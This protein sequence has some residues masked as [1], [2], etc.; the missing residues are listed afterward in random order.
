M[1]QIQHLI[2]DLE[3]S[4]PATREAAAHTL[5][6]LGDD[7]RL[8]LPALFSAILR[9]PDACPW[10]GTALARLGHLAPDIDALSSALRSE[11]SHVR[12]WAARIAVNLGPDAEPLIPDLISLL[13]DT[14]HPVTDS[15]AWALGSIGHAA[16]LPLVS[17][18]RSDDA[19]L[20]ARAV[21]A[22]GRY[23]ENAALKLPEIIKSLDDA[24]SSVRKHAAHAVCSLGQSAHPDSS[25]Y[26]ADT[27][28]LLLGALDRIGADSTIDVDEEWF[29]RICGWLRPNAT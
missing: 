9:E 7:A 27:L 5:H 20:R 3:S 26:D 28:A 22:L 21:L 1:D 2:K 15:V 10:V 16:I 19:Q 4:D 6:D 8:A 24:D 17:A 14:H 29:G 23:H 12:F 18:A 11:N 13:C 25:V